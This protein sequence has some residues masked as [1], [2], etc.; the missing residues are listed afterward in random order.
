MFTH[1]HVPHE[2]KKQHVPGRLIHR[3]VIL[4]GITLNGALN[5]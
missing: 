1:V 2:K 4:K 3:G 5:I